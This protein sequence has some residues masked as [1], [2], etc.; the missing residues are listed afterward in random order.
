M[1]LISRILKGAGNRKNTRKPP[2]PANRNRRNQPRVRNF[3][4]SLK[5]VG[6]ILNWSGTV[7][8]CLAAAG[9]LTI[10]LLYGYRYV[11]NSGYFRVKSL[12]VE[13]NFRL[14]SREI[15]ETAGLH[16]GMD[17]LLVSIDEVERNILKNPWVA[18]AS[19]KRLLPDGFAIKVREREPRFWVRHEGTLFYGDS[20]G[21][22]IVAVSPG[23]FASFPALEI[24][25]GAEDMRDKLP[26]L[27]ASLAG[28]GM[29]IDVAAVSLVR[30]SPG[31]GVEVYLESSRLMLSIGQEEWGDNLARLAATLADLARRKEMRGVREV[32]AHGAGVWVIKSQPVITG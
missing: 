8:I 14:S 12:E 19:V 7:C 2:A 13:G 32:R 27:L 11:T 21:R 26:E 22:P 3:P 20:T 29:P 1:G 16:D 9:L 25:P 4:L 30:L 17:A 5:T 6:R 15:L 23:K 31:R 24:E 28:S 18:N 10:G